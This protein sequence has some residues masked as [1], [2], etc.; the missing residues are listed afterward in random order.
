MD[1]GEKLCKSTEFCKA[2]TEMNLIVHSTGGDNKTSNG[3]VE[4]FN[5]TL[6][7]MNR[8]SLDTLKSMLPPF[9]PKGISIQSFWDLCLGYM[10][11]IKRI[12]INSTMG[13]SP[14]FLVF[15]R[16]PKYEDYPTFGSPCEIITNQKDKLVSTSRS[17]YY[18]S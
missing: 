11:Q 12:V 7:S 3:L 16:R 17:G 14:Y 9:L 2:V 10:D 18:I 4:R 5:Q 8:S 6:H 1:E 13:D 15:K